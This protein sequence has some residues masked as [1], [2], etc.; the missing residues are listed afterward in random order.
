MRRKR[1]ISKQKW[2]VFSFDLKKR[3][4]MNAWQREKGVPD[5]RYRSSVLK[6]SLPEGPSVHPRN[7]E[8]PSIR[9]WANRARRRVELKQLKEV[10]RSC[11][12]M[13]WIRLLIGSPL[14][15]L[16]ILSRTTWV[17][18][19]RASKES[20]AIIKPRENRGNESFGGFRTKILSDWTDPPDRLISR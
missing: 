4:K 17:D 14:I 20:T 8:D 10:W 1:Q 18:Q 15:T 6:V 7:T 11:T 12:T 16:W 5:H 2:R 19:W 13:Y 9:G 3:L